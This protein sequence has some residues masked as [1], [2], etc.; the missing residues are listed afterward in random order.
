M[1]EKVTDDAAAYIKSIAEQRGRNV[2]WAEKAVR[3]SVSASETEALQHKLIDLIAL[4]LNDLLKQINGRKVVTP[5]G[6]HILKTEGAALQHVEMSL[7]QR[8]LSMRSPTRTWHT[9]S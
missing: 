8:L 1:G 4:D 9:C 5:A 7:R 2:E 3:E 6:E